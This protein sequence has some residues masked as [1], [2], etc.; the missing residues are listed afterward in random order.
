MA[1]TDHPSSSDDNCLTLPQSETRARTHK[2]LHPL[3]DV[4]SPNGQGQL[5]RAIETQV[6]PR[7]MTAHQTDLGSGYDLQP[8][9]TVATSFSYAEV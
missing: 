3:G 2:I 4:L 8:G 1:G 6:S 7:L 5:R 9:T